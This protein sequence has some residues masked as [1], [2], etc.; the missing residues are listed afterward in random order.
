MACAAI[1]AS[2]WEI[3]TE[4]P[5]TPFSG[6][7]GTQTDPY[8]ISNAQDLVNFSYICKYTR[9]SETKDKYYVLTNDITLNSVSSKEDLRR[10]SCQALEVYR[11]GVYDFGGNF[12]GRGHT[13]TG[14]V[15]GVQEDDGLFGHLEG[16]KIS[17]VTFD[18]VGLV[19]PIERDP[20]AERNETVCWA[21]LAGT[22]ENTFF[23]N[24]HINNAYCF[25]YN[26]SDDPDP[27]LLLGGFVYHTNEI[28]VFNDCSI[29]LDIH[30]QCEA[31]NVGGFVCTNSGELYMN[32]CKV[33]G[34]WSCN[35]RSTDSRPD[36]YIGGV[37]AV[38]EGTTIISQSVSTIKLNYQNDGYDNINNRPYNAYAS[39][40]GLVG[41]NHSSAHLLT[42]KESAF[43]G[44]LKFNL[45]YD[46]AKRYPPVLKG[47]R[48]GGLIGYCNEEAIISDC[49][50][51]GDIN[52]ENTIEDEPHYIAC[53]IGD[54]NDDVEINRCSIVSFDSYYSSISYEEDGRDPVAHYD[55]EVT[56]E[57]S[58]RI[59]YYVKSNG[60]MVSSSCVKNAGNIPTLLVSDTYLSY[61]NVGPRTVWGRYNNSESAYNGAPLPLACGGNSTAYKGAGT[62]EDPYLIETE[63]DLRALATESYS[64]TL[65]GKYYRQT[66][67]IVMSNEPFYA[68]GRDYDYPFLG[69]YDGYGHSITGMVAANGS[70]FAYMCGSVEGL[71]LLDFSA[72]EGCTD[73]APIA[74]SV[75]GNVP[76]STDYYIGTVT[77]CYACGDFW[78]FAKTTYS[79]FKSQSECAGICG[80][81][82]DGS[83]ITNSYF[84]GSLNTYITDDSNDPIV[85]QDAIC[86]VN[87][88]T[89]KYC[90]GIVS[91]SKVYNKV[92]PYL[93]R[94][95]INHHTAEGAEFLSDWYIAVGDTK[96][97]DDSRRLETYQELREK[98]Q[99][100]PFKSTSYLN[101]VNRNTKYYTGNDY[102]GD[103]SE[104]DATRPFFYE[105]QNTVFY[106]N[107]GDERAWQLPNVA[108]NQVDRKTS[109]VPNYIIDPNYDYFFWRGLGNE[110]V[111]YKKEG[112]VTFPLTFN[113]TGWYSLC[114]PCDL[115][116]S[117]L[118]E[119]SKIRAVG[120]VESNNVRLVEVMGV[121]A[122]AACVVYIPTENTGTYNLYLSG[123]LAVEPQK[124]SEYSS[125]VGAFKAATVSNVAVLAVDAEGNP[126]F[127]YME[128]ADLKPFTGYIA[129]ATADITTTDVTGAFLDQAYI[130]NSYTIM[131]YEGQAPTIAVIASFPKDKWS[132]ICLPFD[133]TV[134]QAQELFGADYEVEDYKYAH[135]NESTDDITM[136]F[137]RVDMEN[138]QCP[139]EA[140]KPY[141]IKPSTDFD[142]SQPVS[143]YNISAVTTTFSDYMESSYYGEISVSIEPTYDYLTGKWNYIYNSDSDSGDIMT[144]EGTCKGLS[145]YV[146]VETEKS[147]GYYNNINIVHGITSGVESPTETEAELEVVGIYD[148]SGRRLAAPQPGVNIL[149]MSDGSARKIIRL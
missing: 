83:S 8:R 26:Y 100:A 78:A 52:F 28:V 119:G 79:D 63:E 67:D 113:D 129:E 123:T 75:G 102:G 6:G 105:K 93:Y 48:I 80:A 98:F 125:M 9:A 76:G 44:S 110:I 66:A 20:T 148:L 95:G 46:S 114:L 142:P 51:I 1:S 37:L 128:S 116:L 19:A 65:V 107:E 143:G 35:Y 29:N 106:L 34:V 5:A 147:Y 149:Q 109:T 118:P 91:F 68:I 30:E 69:H 132:A 89:V 88:G 81:V 124:I 10:T 122:G 32:R 7:S 60:N 97:Y 4:M 96:G 117:D 72:A 40:G 131:Q 135:Y 103:T 71:A 49:A 42:I 47:C 144:R 62:K 18:Y 86:N 17:N 50:Y 24:V 43:M 133:L 56:L 137:G 139:I 61:L 22:A 92:E 94:P 21:I 13:I 90:Y 55:D 31:S 126:Y 112:K 53:L 141:L 82:Y 57:N 64:N 70:M 77:N 58:G 2:A 127:Q 59:Y 146:N 27:N 134:E 115:Y 136:F 120:E 23:N 73:V 121:P 138:I 101:P 16:A 99:N 11:F 45:S 87:Y 36:F 15:C 108:I 25:N 85:Y 84:V 111:N 38:N 39:F 54:V 14:Y 12:D 140:G 130:S 104:I 3:P 33:G 74:M 145:F 41:Q